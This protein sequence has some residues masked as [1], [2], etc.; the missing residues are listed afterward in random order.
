MKFGQGF[1]LWYNP[2]NELEIV[3]FVA[4]WLVSPYLTFQ[5]IVYKRAL[6]LKCCHSFRIGRHLKTSSLSS[7]VFYASSLVSCRKSASKIQRWVRL[8]LIYEPH[9]TTK[10]GQ[11]Q[12]SIAV[13]LYCQVSVIY[14]FSEHCSVSRNVNRIHKLIQCLQCLQ[15]GFE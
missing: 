13:T 5:K 8:I 14:V 1:Q 4:D 2:G 12:S 10:V 11:S 3:G 15:R 6:Y 9:L 7:S